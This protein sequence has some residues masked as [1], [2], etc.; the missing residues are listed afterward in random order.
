MQQQEI[1]NTKKT[2]KGQVIKMKVDSKTIYQEITTLAKR[3][4][5]NTDVNLS[6]EDKMNMI[7]KLVEIR[8]MFY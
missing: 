5:D 4:G 6:A 3:I 1:I 2:I 8:G 7:A